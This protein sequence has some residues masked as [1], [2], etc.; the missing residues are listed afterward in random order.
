[1]TLALLCTLAQATWADTDYT[2]SYI[3]YT[4]NSDGETITKNTGSVNTYFPLSYN[5]IH[6]TKEDNLF[7]DWYVLNSNLTYPERIVISGNDVHIILCDGC[8]L[9]AEQGIRIDPGAK[10][11][12]Y[13]QSE[14]EG[15]M[16]K[17]VAIETHHD[18][19][20]IGGNKNYRAGT[21]II[22]GG[23]IEADASEGKYA[24]GIGG[25]Y[26]DGSGMEGITIYGGKVTAQ[27]SKTGAGIGGGKNNNY[28]GTINIYG[29]TINATG[30]EYGA[31]IGGGQNR[32]GWK[33]IIYGG[34]IMATGGGNGAGIGGGE[35]GKGNYIEI[36]DG[37]ISAYGNNGAGIGGGSGIDTPL[38][39]TVH[40][41]GGTIKIHGGTVHAWNAY[42]GCGVAI[43]GGKCGSAGT[44]VIDG[45]HVTAEGH[46]TLY[47]SKS[48]PTEASAIGAGVFGSGGTV[49][50]TGDADVTLIREFDEMGDE[51]DAARLVSATLTL[52]DNLCLTDKEKTYNASERVEQ[53]TKE[54]HK[55]LYIKP[56]THGDYT[57]SYINSSG[58][59]AHCAYCEYTKNEEHGF[60]GSSSLCSACGY[61]QG[62]TICTLSFFQTQTESAT[63]YMTAG[64]QYV[65]GQTIALPDCTRVPDGM[66]FVG[67]LKQDSTPSSIEAADGEATLLKP[68]DKFKV[69]G[70]EVFYARYRY[71][72]AET[73]M[74]DATLANAS[75]TI[76]AG[77]GEAIYLT[78][79]V[80]DRT[81]TAATDAADGSIT[82]TATATY[83]HGSTTYT[84]SST[85]T[86]ELSYSLSLDESDNTETLT[87]YD[88]R[89]MNITLAGRTLYKDGLWN[90]LCLPFDVDDISGSPLAGATLKELS[91]A[92]FADGT[93][94]L[95][96]AEATSIQAGQA[97]LIKWDK[98]DGYDSASEDTRDIK[99][100]VFPG[101]TL[102]KDLRDDE[103]STDDSGTATV[104]FMGTYK[105]LSYDAD[106]RTVL[107][108]GANNTLYYP[109][110][111]A[112]IG[113]QRAYF[114]LNGLTVGN[115]V[116]SAIVLNFG[117][118]ETTGIGSIDNGELR[119]DNDD[120]YSLDGR[121]LD[122]KPTARGIYINN[123]KKFVI[124]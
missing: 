84:F 80:S 69:T 111:G 43:G 70:S 106:D 33:T 97:Y 57:Y 11:T 104:T 42:W 59:T 51:L 18:K 90:T 9:T 20:A 100:P 103:I 29:G 26:G 117:D 96:F 75:L 98:A 28:P 86:K 40:G 78:P 1:M 30:G 107:F 65:D 122:G 118:G 27:G 62:V 89:S 53:C 87:T 35:K 112:S 38:A 54:K 123:G 55:V 44:I 74:W 81:E 19:A 23:E 16:G 85:Q 67:W 34:T 121:K 46:T 24:A 56:C 47:S 83:T 109:Q 82:A 17:L 50:I 114:K 6:N 108:L 101:V 113:A 3:Y 110:S 124:K 94:T 99:T 31:G 72:F 5:L 79:T 63:D 119:I 10:L 95:T 2:V 7:E 115:I 92:T 41:D 36:F 14:V 60:V 88:G 93:L 32:D 61:I 68:G 37:T 4:V 13:A 22:H 64:T 105:K 76:K 73:W 120:W 58:H 66:R 52:G 49:E 102:A 45:G 77:S 12:I 71:D 48:G 8:T 21:L 116:N 25:G 91:D 15:T 39:R